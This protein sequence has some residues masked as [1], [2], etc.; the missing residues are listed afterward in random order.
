MK[1]TLRILVNHLARMV[2][3]DLKLNKDETIDLVLRAYN[4][5][6]ESERDSADYILSIDSNEDV[7]TC[8]QGGM[9]IDEVV[10]LRNS[11]NNDEATEYFMFGHNHEK[12][13]QI[14]DKEQLA[15]IIGF[16]DELFEDIIKY[17][18]AFKSYED[19]YRTYITDTML[20]DI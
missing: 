5:Y 19:V 18:Y 12:P 3:R 1:T 9:T 17:P 4:D 11:Y 2:R 8:L 6:E 16:N 15:G 7:I 14:M 10:R 20:D 13:N